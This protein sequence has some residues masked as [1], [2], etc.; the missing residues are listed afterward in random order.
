M[1]TSSSSQLAGV[2]PHAPASHASSS[3][4]GLPSSQGAVLS[5][6]SQP[7]PNAQ[8]FVVQGSPSSQLTSEPWHRPLAHTSFSVQ[9]SASSQGA[10]LNW[11]THVPPWQ[12]SSVQG[13]PSS[14]A[15]ALGT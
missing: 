14:Q 11:P 12:E 5:I 7:S 4:Q 10:A 15:A 2:P 9:T 1:Q 13:L 8:K 3:V 6:A